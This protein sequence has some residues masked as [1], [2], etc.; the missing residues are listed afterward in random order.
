MFRQGMTKNDGDYSWLGNV[1]FLLSYL[2]ASS[3]LLLYAE[4]REVLSS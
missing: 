3:L 4:I 2:Q 1:M